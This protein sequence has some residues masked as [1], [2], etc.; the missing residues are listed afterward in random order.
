MLKIA[1][2]KNRLLSPLTQDSVRAGFKPTPTISGLLETRIPGKSNIME[3]QS[4][5]QLFTTFWA[6]MAELH[7]PFLISRLQ[8]KRRFFG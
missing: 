1:K 7:F 3:K 8:V 5:S 4:R 2:T 6:I